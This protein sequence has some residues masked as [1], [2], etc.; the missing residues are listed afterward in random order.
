MRFYACGNLAAVDFRISSTCRA[1]EEVSLHIAA[2]SREYIKIG[3]HDEV[4]EQFQRIS[5]FPNVMGVV[6]CT[7]IRL[8]PPRQS[9]DDAYGNREEFVSMNIQAVSN[10]HFIIQDIVAR[11]PGST[12]KITI[13]DN[14]RLTSRWE[15]GEFE[16]NSAYNAISKC[17]E[18]WR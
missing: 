6:G 7:H 17:F 4:V 5:K 18:V 8:K 13:F 12:Q 3:G 1:V 14:S 15:G 2:L 9:Q 10:A 16:D 11:W